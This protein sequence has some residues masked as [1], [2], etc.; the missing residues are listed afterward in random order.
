VLESPHRHQKK[1]RIYG[2][3]LEVMVPGSDIVVSREPTLNEAHTDVNVAIRD[4]FAAAARQL[5]DHT[6][7][8]RGYVK[9]HGVPLHGRVVRMFRDDGYGFIETPDGLEIY[10]HENSVADDAFGKLEHGSEVRLELADGEGEK[11][12][13][14]STVQ[15]LGKRHILE[16]EPLA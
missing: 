1:G 10:F 15:L 14:A 4:A 11:G 2:V 7:R 8:R 5:E 13:Q 6:R 3:R 9:A 12:P 16:H